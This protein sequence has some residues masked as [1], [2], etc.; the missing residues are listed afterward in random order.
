MKNTHNCTHP[1][2]QTYTYIQSFKHVDSPT[3]SDWTTRCTDVTIYLCLSS[4]QKHIN[5]DAHQYVNTYKQKLNLWILTYS[6]H[7]NIHTYIN[8]S[9]VTQINN[10]YRYTLRMPYLSLFLLLLPL[11]CWYLLISTYATLVYVTNTL[12][13]LTTSPFFQLFSYSF[14]SFFLLFS[15]FF[16]PRS[17]DRGQLLESR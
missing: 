2:R 8:T 10:N 15:F 13:T 6:R 16:S 1:N 4:T 7:A 12:S 17:A 3:G 9:T 5:T 11:F 14:H